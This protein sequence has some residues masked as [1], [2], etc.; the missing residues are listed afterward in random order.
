MPTEKDAS[1]YSGNDGQLR[2]EFFQ[3]ES[4]QFAFSVCRALVCGSLKG[5][6]YVKGNFT[7]TRFKELL[8]SADSKH[9]WF[10]KGLTPRL[11][12]FALVA[13]EVFDI[14]YNEHSKPQAFTF[15]F[16]KKPLHP[17]R[18]RRFDRNIAVNPAEPVHLTKYFMNDD[19]F[20]GNVVGK[21]A[22]GNPYVVSEES[23]AGLAG[24]NWQRIPME[25]VNPILSE[26]IR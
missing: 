11:M 15:I 10:L 25:H 14:R 21:L 17:G 8:H 19:G 4:I 1:N 7:V 3:P 2:K 12:S 6:R 26:F 24:P 13:N 23:A 9:T 18:L 20:P 5:N 16:N 22:P